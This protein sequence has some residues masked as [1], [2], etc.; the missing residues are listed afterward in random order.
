MK[1]QEASSLFGVLLKIAMF[2]PNCAVFAFAASAC[3]RFAMLQCEPL[4]SATSFTNGSQ[5]VE[6]M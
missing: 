5:E 1:S 6:E 2:A 4:L 3:G